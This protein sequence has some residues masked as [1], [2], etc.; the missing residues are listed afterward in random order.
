MQHIKVSKF[1]KNVVLSVMNLCMCRLFDSLTVLGHLLSQSCVFLV[2]MS[3]MWIYVM[4]CVW[5]A[6][7]MLCWTWHTNFVTIFFHTCR[8]YRHH[9]LLPY[10]TTF[11]DHDL[12]W[13]SQDQHKAKPFG[14]IL[15]GTFH[16]ISMKF[17]IVLKYSRLKI[18]FLS[19]IKWNKGNNCCFTDCVK[20]I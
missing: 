13:G 17:D 12:A 7:L 2:H 11:T 9:W 6:I 5:P 3:I 8:A 18:L 4:S 19:E 20:N 10:Y 15:A 14:F 1:S 16:L